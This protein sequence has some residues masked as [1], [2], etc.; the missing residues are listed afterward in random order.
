MRKKIKMREND[1]ILVHS[2]L[3][4][5]G[6]LGQKWGVRRYQNEDRTWTEAGKKRYGHGQV[7]D[8]GKKYY[9]A[10]KT[11][12]QEYKTRAQ[13]LDVK[14]K[15]INN[16]TNLSKEEKRNYDYAVS[17]EFA[18]KLDK[19]DEKLK[20]AKKEYKDST[21]LGQRVSDKWNNL[22]PKTQKAIKVGAAVAGTALVTYGAY[23]LHEANS[24]KSFNNSI[25]L[26]KDT[27]KKIEYEKFEYDRFEPERFGSSKSL[28]DDLK[29]VGKN[30]DMSPEAYGKKA[31][32]ERIAKNNNLDSQ[33]NAV[34]NAKENAKEVAKTTTPEGGFTNE[35]LQYGSKSG[36]RAQSIKNRV[37]LSA[38]VFNNT[39]SDLNKKYSSG[40]LTN[41]EYENAIS[42]REDT[43]R[44]ATRSYRSLADNIGVEW[45]KSY[46]DGVVKAAKD[47]VAK[48]KKAMDPT[49]SNNKYA[50]SFNLD[51]NDTPQQVYQK[52][53]SQ[54]Q[55]LF[56]MSIEEL[57]KK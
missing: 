53:M 57:L 48:V 14:S 33:M 13:D 45:D 10:K 42:S 37:D 36:I 41:R 27:Y 6:I 1:Y 28:A 24:N 43:Y 16:A 5:H 2:E 44:N 25:D 35:K 51:I 50:F 18:K 9:E 15:L 17:M 4:H 21:S 12:K 49:S 52:I 32:A 30:S 47:S 19:S 54:N 8:A 38:R 20:A 29:A 31:A 26:G 55:E 11:R 34:R 39:I 40:L 7:S 46:S 3:Y 23:K 56:N 22:D